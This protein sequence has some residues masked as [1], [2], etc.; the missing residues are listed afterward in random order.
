[1]LKGLSLSWTGDVV[2]GEPTTAG[3]MGGPGNEL[4]GVKSGWTGLDAT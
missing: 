2:F 3:H 4:T 1:M